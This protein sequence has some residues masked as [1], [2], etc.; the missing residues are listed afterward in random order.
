MTPI[1]ISLASSNF[2]EKVLGESLKLMIY[3]IVQEQINNILKHAAASKVTISIETDTDNIYLS[4]VDNG[5][6]FDSNKKSKGIGLRN[7]DNRVKFY[8]GTANII[9]GNGK[10]CRLEISVPLENQL[11]LA[12]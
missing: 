7:I 6:G 9:S 2:N 10:G 12:G 1:S 3:R 11:K 8:S 5:I 4:I